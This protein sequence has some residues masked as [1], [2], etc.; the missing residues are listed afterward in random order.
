MT[1]KHKKAYIAPR[2][3]EI[4]VEGTSYL[5]QT[6]WSISDANGKWVDG[7]KIKNENPSGGIDSRS[8][9]FG[10]SPFASKPSDI[11]WEN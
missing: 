8:R 1:G 10:D 7:G 4:I 9:I 11:P 2:V 3:E 5:S 6:S